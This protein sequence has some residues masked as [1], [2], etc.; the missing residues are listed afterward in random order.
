MG[1][2]IAASLRNLKPWSK[3]QKRA[4]SLELYNPCD[5]YGN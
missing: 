4:F 2:A 1:L 5:A 3:H